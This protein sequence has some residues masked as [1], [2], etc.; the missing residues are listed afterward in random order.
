MAEDTAAGAAV[1]F[2]EAAGAADFMAVEEGFTAEEDSPAEAA[3]VS[4]EA[5]RLVAGIAAVTVA[6]D[7]M[8]A[9]AVMDGVAAAG[10]AE[11]GV[12][13][14]VMDGAV[15]AG[16]LGMG[17]RIGDMDGAI[18]TVTT[19][20]AGDITRPTVIMVTRPTGLRTT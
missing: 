3:L 12:E 7:S 10:A 15:G 5:A 14:T 11:V 9:A 16:D 4:A 18:R 17:G 20:T 6:A 1:V 19:A 13:D 2:T 8:A